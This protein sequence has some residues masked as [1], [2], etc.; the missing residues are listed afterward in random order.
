METFSHS[1]KLGMITKSY[2]L[3]GLP[4]ETHEMF[5][6]TVRINKY[7]QPD[8]TMLNIFYPYPGTQL[9][10]ICDELGLKSNDEDDNIRERTASILSLPDFPKDNIMYYFNNWQKLIK[11]TLCQRIKK[12]VKKRMYRI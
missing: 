9:D 11:G 10:K 6:D 8:E 2:N 12:I 1:R 3:I 7:I 4:H 5:E